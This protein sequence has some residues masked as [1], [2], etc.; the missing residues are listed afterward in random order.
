MLGLS[1]RLLAENQKFL[2]FFDNL[3]LPKALCP[4]FQPC[5]SNSTT[6]YLYGCTKYEYVGYHCD[7]IPNEFESYQALANFT[8]VAS[9]TRE[10]DYVD[11]KYGKGIHTTGPHELESLRAKVIDSY[12]APQF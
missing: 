8:K 7:T 5:V 1:G 9:A 11:S 4:K 10:P 3:I 6:S 12:N 2:K